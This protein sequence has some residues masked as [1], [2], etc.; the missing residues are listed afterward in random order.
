MSNT[1]R[2]RVA[3]LLLGHD[4]GDGRLGPRIAETMRAEIYRALAGV[5]CETERVA[6]SL[7]ARAPGLAADIRRD[8]AWAYRSLREMNGVVWSQAS[9]RRVRAA[10][11]AVSMDFLPEAACAGMRGPDMPL[12][13]AERVSARAPGGMG[14]LSERLYRAGVYHTLYLIAAGRGDNARAQDLRVALHDTLADLADEVVKRANSLRKHGLDDEADALA[15][16]WAW[17]DGAR[18]P[19]GRTLLHEGPQEGS[20]DALAEAGALPAICE[21]APQCQIPSPTGVWKERVAEWREEERIR[22]DKAR[23]DKAWD[24]LVNGF[25]PGAASVIPDQD[26]EL[27]PAG[28]GAGLG[29]FEFNEFG[30]LRRATGVEPMV[31]IDTGTGEPRSHVPMRLIPEISNAEAVTAEAGEPLLAG[32]VREVLAA[33]GKEAIAVHMGKAESRETRAAGGPEKGTTLI[34]WLGS[35]EIEWIKSDKLQVASRQVFVYGPAEMKTTLGLAQFCFGKWVDFSTLRIQEHRNLFCVGDEVELPAATL[36]HYGTAVIGCDIPRGDRTTTLP[37]MC[38]GV[39]VRAPAGRATAQAEPMYD[40]EVGNT[41][42]LG[43]KESDLRPRKGKVKVQPRTDI[44]NLAG[45]SYNA[46]DSDAYR[47]YRGES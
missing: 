10:L 35:G 43:Q 7:R 12:R 45:Q 19:I 21:T 30:H 2:R 31:H 44:R 41:V 28:H 36:K 42:L 46:F 14:S 13:E 23:A 39:V 8:A 22:T 38:A 26:I 27:H 16:D 17:I 47:R 37:D 25:R 32:A 40:V 11:E 24:T 3:E 4:T 6:K 1:A 29:M 15:G 5:V 33:D 9:D 18:E 20:L 34:Q